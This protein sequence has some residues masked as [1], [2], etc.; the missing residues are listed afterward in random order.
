MG[1]ERGG[2]AGIRVRLARANHRTMCA[3]GTPGRPGPFML[4][5]IDPASLPGYGYHPGAFTGALLSMAARL[6][7]LYPVYPAAIQRWEK[8]GPADALGEVTYQIAVEADGKVDLTRAVS[9]N[10]QE[11]IVS[12]SWQA[13]GRSRCTARRRFRPRSSRFPRPGRRRVIA[14]RELAFL[15][16][17][18]NK[19]GCAH[20]GAGRAWPGAHR[21]RPGS[22]GCTAPASTHARA[23]CRW[24]G[25]PPRGTA[26]TLGQPRPH[27]LVAQD[28]AL[29]RR[30]SGVRIPLGVPPRR[31]AAPPLP[32][33]A[34]AVTIA[35]AASTSAH[36]WPSSRWT[37]AMC[38]GSCRSAPST[39]N[40]SPKPFMEPSSSR[41]RAHARS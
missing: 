20:R 34:R 1:T 24:G 15:A 5:F 40:L 8:A 14:T 27:R 29:S 10:R 7:A 25:L 3:P 16:R 30:K 23:R 17:Q 26:A 2:R 12:E 21:I 28:A 41:N 31:S 36:A 33:G 18:R 9:V 22:R 4:L 37:C 32:G 35:H 39:V 19:Q 6:V 13:Y 38:S 11:Q